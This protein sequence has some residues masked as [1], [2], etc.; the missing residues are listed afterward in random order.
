MLIWT[1]P[2]GIFASNWTLPYRMLW[3]AFVVMRADLTG[4]R[5]LPVD[6]FD[7]I[8]HIGPVLFDAVHVSERSS[9]YPFVIWASVRT[10]VVRVGTM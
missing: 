6:E 4:G 5:M 1:D 7:C 9:L 10:S 3:V 2:V 8:T